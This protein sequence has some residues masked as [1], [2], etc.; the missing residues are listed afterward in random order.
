MIKII[1]TTA[2]I[3]FISQSIFAFEIDFSRRKSFMKSN[4][5][6]GEAPQFTLTPEPTSVERVKVNF[7]SSQDVVIL[8]TEKGFVPR[9]LSLREGVKYTIHVVNVNEKEKNVSFIMSAFA[10]H[11]GTYYGQIKTFDVV[12][13]KE[14]VYTYQCP[15]T[16]LEGKVV[17]LPTDRAIAS[18][19]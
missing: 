2:I 17:V 3:I 12:P 13:Q 14:G 11:H 19:K 5:V 10:Q 7:E 18:E 9:S 8:N 16:S 15:E 6:Q 1:T 4:E